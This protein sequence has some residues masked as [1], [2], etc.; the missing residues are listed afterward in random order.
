MKEKYIEQVKKEL[1]VSQKQKKEVVRDLNEAFASAS[2]HGETEQQVMERLGSPKEFAGNIHEQLGISSGKRK[3]RKKLFQITIA[4][5]VSVVSFS[6]SF[7]AKALRAPQNIIG[8]ADSMTSIK[9]EG[10]AIDPM[11]LFILL[12]IA[13]LAVVIILAVQYLCK[14]SLR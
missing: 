13:A 1:A 6:L 7:L 11:I 10:P 14:S 2:E 5:I 4:A 8:Q 9:V 3:K 12:G